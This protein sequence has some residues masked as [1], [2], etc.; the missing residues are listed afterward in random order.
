MVIL[1]VAV[2]LI[3]AYIFK[4]NESDPDSMIGKN[5]DS[6]NQ[7]NPNFWRDL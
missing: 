3:A 7:V 4:K 5:N 6:K 2:F 1:I